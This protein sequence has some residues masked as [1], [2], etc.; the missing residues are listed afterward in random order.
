MDI[1]GKEEQGQ[2][3]NELVVAGAVLFG[4]VA[5]VSA[6]AYLIT[7]GDRQYIAD[8]R[9]P[10]IIPSNA[11]PIAQDNT[12]QLEFVVWNKD[13]KKISCGSDITSTVDYTPDT[14]EKTTKDILPFAKAPLSQSVVVCYNYGD[15]IDDIP[16]KAFPSAYDT[17]PLVATPQLVEVS[18]QLKAALDAE[19][20]K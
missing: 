10:L 13:L 14:V 19:Q 11:Q 3:A 4:V 12:H 9:K 6:G 17:P 15:H 5:V 1:R 18:Y 8:S 16:T 7:T 2:N 20:D